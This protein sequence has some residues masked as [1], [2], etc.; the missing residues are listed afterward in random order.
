MKLMGS[1][2]WITAVGAG[3]LEVPPI[4]TSSAQTHRGTL[5]TTLTPKC[6]H[7]TPWG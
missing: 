4:G 1:R 6:R 7:S 5:G 2:V 3:A